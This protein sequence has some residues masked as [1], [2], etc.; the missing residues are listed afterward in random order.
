[1]GNFQPHLREPLDLKKYAGTWYEVARS[2]NPF[3]FDCARAKATY[4][5]DGSGTMGIEN[6]CY[7][8]N[9][10]IIKKPWLARARVGS[11]KYPRALEIFEMNGRRAPP[12]LEGNYYVHVTDYETYAIVGSDLYIWLLWR[13]GDPETGKANIT[14]DEYRKLFETAKPF[15]PLG[16]W[17]I[18]RSG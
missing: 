13:K 5:V 10:A 8:I 17:L 15:A 1:M 7:D 11:Q 4:T 9:G 18:R 12:G 6:L 3:Q 2:P 16:W 14:S